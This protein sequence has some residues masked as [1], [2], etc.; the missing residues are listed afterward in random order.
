[1]VAGHLR[2]LRQGDDGQRVSS[3]LDLIVLPHARG[4]LAAG[5]LAGFDV[6]QEV[7]DRACRRL[8]QPPVQGRLVELQHSVG[9][10]RMT[11]DVVLAPGRVRLREVGVDKAAVGADRGLQIL[12]RHASGREQ[13]LRRELVIAAMPAV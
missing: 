5:S 13:G 2:V 3:E 4:L 11:Q 7:V 12:A 1:M 10:A 6:R 9:R 8:E